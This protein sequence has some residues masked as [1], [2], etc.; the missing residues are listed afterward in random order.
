MMTGMP[1]LNHK[2]S[3]SDDIESQKAAMAMLRKREKLNEELKK[4]GSKSRVRARTKM[5][6]LQRTRAFTANESERMN[7]EK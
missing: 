3:A 2:T 6:T 4:N 1:S 5:N 7:E